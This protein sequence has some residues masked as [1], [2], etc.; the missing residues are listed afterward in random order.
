MLRSFLAALQSRQD[1]LESTGYHLY[2]RTYTSPLLLSEEVEFEVL[3][4]KRLVPGISL[5]QNAALKLLQ[6]LAPY[7]AELDSIPYER[8]GTDPGF[9]FA[10]SWYND[11]DAATLYGLLRHLKPPR[12]IELGCG[13]SSLVSSRAL[14]RNGQDGFACDVVYADPN[15][16]L[17]IARLLAR[18]NLINQRVQDLP[19]DLFTALEAGDVLFVDTSHVVKL[20][21]DVVRLLVT[22]LPSLK[23]GVWIHIHDVFTPYEY[24]VD[25]V[26]NPLFSNNEQYA[27][28]ALLSGGD[29]YSV[30][31]PLYLLWNEH[32]NEMHTFFPRGRLRPQALWIRTR[33]TRPPAEDLA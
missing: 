31:L 20:Q 27:L 13:F 2:P 1:V 25:W 15:P 29:R 16:R 3:Q 19:L 23:P 4:H 30:E 32:L 11:F 14:Q 21:S 28:E 24:P 6:H 26:T 8:G 22:I 17:D 5:N 12:Y 9:W 18:G 10:N 33:E 7:T